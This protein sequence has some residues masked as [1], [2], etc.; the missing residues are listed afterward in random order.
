MHW[1][2]ASWV[3]RK[4]LSC[5]PLPRL[6][7][8]LP[9]P[10]RPQHPLPDLISAFSA[11]RC[12]L[13]SARVAFPKSC[14]PLPAPYIRASCGSQGSVEMPQHGQRAPSSGLRISSAA[15]WLDVQFWGHFL[16]TPFA[17]IG[18]AT[19]L[20]PAGFD[21]TL[22]GLPGCFHFLTCFRSGLVPP[23]PCSSTASAHA[24]EGH[25]SHCAVM[26]GFPWS[27]PSPHW[28]TDSEVFPS[29][30]FSCWTQLQRRLDHVGATKPLPQVFTYIFLN[31]LRMSCSHHDIS[32][33][34]VSPARP[35]NKETPP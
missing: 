9:R 3:S 21:P 23:M 12:V 5:L 2:L 35:K 7:P 30:S 18:Y 19:S 1:V 8:Q 15:P 26:G 11:L 28:V 16:N 6:L 17:L 34:S 25:L 29:N 20:P 13:T 32:S 22:L 4:H 10:Q 27:L 24:S 14:P 31:Y 33:L